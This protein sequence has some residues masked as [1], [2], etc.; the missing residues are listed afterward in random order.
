MSFEISVWRKLPGVTWV[1]VV[2]LGSDS[3]LLGV[4]WGCVTQCS[5]LLT[6]VSQQELVYKS[7]SLRLKPSERSRCSRFSPFSQLPAHTVRKSKKTNCYSRN[8]RQDTNTGE[9]TDYHDSVAILAGSYRPLIPP[10]IH[11][12]R[13]YNSCNRRPSSSLTNSIN[14][15]S[16]LMKSFRSSRMTS[17]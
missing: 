4:T 2:L 6:Q 7:Y 3:V 13:V 9:E 1:Y 8:S 16:N 12:L 5:S 17:A 10:D 15:N 11:M 14:S